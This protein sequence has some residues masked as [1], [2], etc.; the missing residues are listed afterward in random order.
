M[1]SVLFCFE[2]SLQ[3]VLFRWW[4]QHPRK[5]RQWAKSNE[6][7]IT[8]FMQHDTWPKAFSQHNYSCQ[9]FA[10]A[11]TSRGNSDR[12]MPL[13][14]PSFA[15]VLHN[16]TSTLRQVHGWQTAVVTCLSHQQLGVPQWYICVPTTVQC[17]SL[18]HHVQTHR[19]D[20]QIHCVICWRKFVF[21][22]EPEACVCIIALL[23]VLPLFE[24]NTSNWK[25]GVCPLSTF[26]HWF[27]CDQHQAV[28]SCPALYSRLAQSIFNVKY[29]P[30]GSDKA[31]AQVV[32][33]VCWRTCQWHLCRR[34]FWE[35]AQLDTFR[36]RCTKLVPGRVEVTCWQ[37]SLGATWP[38]IMSAFVSQKHN[39]S[40]SISHESL[41]S[42]V[43]CLFEYNSLLAQVLPSSQLHI[44]M[45][46]RKILCS[47][48][49]EKR[50]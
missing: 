2:N 19:Q 22:A 28:S 48:Q 33:T 9:I 27:I 47:S 34:N 31:F 23:W 15:C 39:H 41:F 26:W 40:V 50:V 11:G 20:A 18:E 14:G 21:H 49:W 35:L 46:L 13:S 25:S 32:K 10:A 6:L 38:P 29:G 44:S 36:L 30:L 8:L 3:V 37:V 45:S 5:L 12:D 16:G 7:V 24:E 42:F 17:K 43:P 1:K 4:A